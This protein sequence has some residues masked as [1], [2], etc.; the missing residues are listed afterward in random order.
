[1]DKIWPLISGF[2]DQEPNPQLPEDAGDWYTG[3]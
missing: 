2:L 3:G 1:V